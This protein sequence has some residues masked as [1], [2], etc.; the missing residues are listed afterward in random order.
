M[1]LLKIRYDCLLHDLMVAKLEAYGFAKE[2]LQLISHY[3]KYRKQRTKIGSAYSCWANVIRGIPQCSILGALLFYIFINDIFLVAGKSDIFNFAD[4]TA[5]NFHGS[6]ILL[7]L[8]NLE[9]HMRNLLYWFKINSLMANP[10]N[11]QFVILWKKDRLKYSLETGSITIK[12]SEVELL[13]R[14]NDEVL[15]FKKTCPMTNQK[16]LDTD[17]AKL[18]CNASST[19]HH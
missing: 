10:G 7:I 5:L 19:M 6:N 15:N 9:Y 17:K 14:T 11:F 16:I 8:S 4:D 13:G 12:E 2:S 18:L 1:V 3:L